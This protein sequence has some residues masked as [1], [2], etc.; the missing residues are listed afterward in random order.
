[1]LYCKSLD[2][3]QILYIKLSSIDL[4]QYIVITY[5][6]LHVNYILKIYGLGLIPLFPTTQ[7]D[8]HHERNYSFK[9]SVVK[10]REGLTISIN[11]GRDW[12]FPLII[13]L[14]GMFTCHIISHQLCWQYEMISSMHCI[15]M[16]IKFVL[17][18]RNWFNAHCVWRCVK[19]L[20]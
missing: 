15:W 20:S 12:P 8:L 10:I 7:L 18:F 14:L 4:I 2:K 19:I 16:Y 6:T 9:H 3:S 17:S 1:M 5:K 11:L 13:N